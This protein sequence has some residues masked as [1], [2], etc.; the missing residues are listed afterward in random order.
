MANLTAR[1]LTVLCAAALLALAA[2]SAPHSGAD[3]VSAEQKPLASGL[4]PPFDVLAVRASAGRPAGSEPFVCD[5]VPPAVVE[6]SMESKYARTKGSA[7]LDPKREEAN[8][9]AMAP[10]NAYVRPLIKMAN[11]FVLSN[12]PQSAAARCVMT[13]LVA[14]AKADAMSVATTGQGEMVR[15]WN[16]PIFA[17]SYIQV[18]NDTS[19]NPA[20]AAAVEA[21][22]GRLADKVVADFN[23]EP[24]RGSRRNNHRY[25]AGWGVMTAALAL[26]DRALMDWAIE[27]YRIGIRQVTAEGFLPLELDR[28]Q[29][30]LG[31]HIYAAQPLVMIAE[32]AAVN[33]IDLYSEN[34][35]ALHRLIRWSLDGLD[36]PKAFND[37]VGIV[38]DISDAATASK[39]AWLVPYERRFG[40]SDLARWRTVHKSFKSSKLGGDVDLLYGG[41]LEP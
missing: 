27:S 5:P 40:G 20:D 35:G 30:A 3:L 16:L 21:W 33:G 25:W 28:R 14:W 2:C 32:A 31:Y 24:E 34:D 12:P 13:W 1:G 41:A 18:R 9:A 39:M 15:G 19:L 38:Q 23:R 22:L 10:V 8:K 37:R 4:R 7:D 11:G 17:L 29:R 6:L 36:D 26:D